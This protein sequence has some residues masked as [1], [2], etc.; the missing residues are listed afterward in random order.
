MWLTGWGSRRWSR[1]TT[2]LEKEL[3]G[4]ALTP[5]G[6]QASF[7]LPWMRNR[8]CWPAELWGAA[9]KMWGVLWLRQLPQPCSKRQRLH[10]PGDKDAEE[11]PWAQRT[12]LIV[13]CCS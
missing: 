9:R 5:P 7:M 2:G 6:C 13:S 3:E 11:G 4:W 10:L 12:L 1:K 8:Q